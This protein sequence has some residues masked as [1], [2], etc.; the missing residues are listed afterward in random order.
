MS[1][2]RPAASRPSVLGA[3]FRPPHCPNRDC[4]HY[5]PSPNWRWRKNGSFAR[6]G[7]LTRFQC[8][9]CRRCGR[10]FSLRTFAADYWLKHRRLFPHLV[11]WSVEGPALRQTARRF[12]VAHSTVARHVARAARFA[13]LFHRLTIRDQS[14]REPLAVDGFESF[15][16]SQ[17]FPFHLNLAAGTQSWFIYGFTESPLRRKGRMTALQRRRRGELEGTFGTPD[18]KAVEQGMA[19]LL[20]LVLGP[21]RVARGAPSLDLHSDDHPAY[22]RALR[23]FR[24]ETNRR[25]Q[26]HVTPGTEPRTTSNPLFAVNLADLLLRHGQANHR[27]ESIAFS[28]RRQ[29]AIERA[30]VFLYWRNYGKWRREKAPGETAAMAARIVPGRLTWGDLLR[31]RWF[32][33]PP[34]LPSPWS[35]FYWRRIRTAVF[36]DRQATHALRYAF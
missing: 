36:G 8:F 23:T 35:D 30:A 21:E 15:E 11:A 19:A 13:L 17:F 34:L 31:R 28:K 12:D 22:R 29:G 18:P 2:L 25:V 24:L 27:R 3:D 6:P 14:L 16:Y 20:R 4:P 5:A 32:P 26:H 33:R 1:T 7:E 10:Y 9:Q